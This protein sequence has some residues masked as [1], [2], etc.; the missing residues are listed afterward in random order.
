M[1]FYYLTRETISLNKLLLKRIVTLT[2]LFLILLI[3]DLSTEDSL[4]LN[5]PGEADVL[6]VL[7]DKGN[8]EEDLL[9][10]FEDFYTAQQESI[11]EEQAK[12]E[13]ELDRLE[14][15]RL[16]ALDDDNDDNEK[17]AET[18]AYTLED[19]DKDTDYANLFDPSID[20]TFIIDFTSLEWDGL[21]DDMEEYHEQYGTYK[22]NNYRQVDVTYYS[23]NEQIF[24]QDVGIRSK[25]NVYSRILPEDETGYHDIHYAL[26]FNETFDTFEGTEAHTNLK[27]R[28]VFDLEK[29]YFKWNKN[30]DQS[31]IS[32]IYSNHLFREAGVIAPNCNL[33]KFVIRIDGEV[34]QTSLYTV[35]ESLDEEFVRRYFQE[36]PTKEVGD[37][38]KVVYPGTLEALTSTDYYFIAQDNPSYPNANIITYGVR[39]W[40]LNE[41]PTYG[42]ETNDDVIN[43]DNLIDFT[44]DLNNFSGAHLKIY[45]EA[46]FDVDSFLRSL[47]C[48]VFLGNPDDYR[49]NVNNYYLYFDE[50]NYLTYIP[51]DYDW[52]MGQHWSEDN[53]SM[54][55]DIYNWTQ[56]TNRNTPLVDEILAIEEY[57][58]I[59]ENYLEQ[60]INDSTFS[61]QSFAT[62][63]NQ[64]EDIYGDEFNMSNDKSFYITSKIEHVLEDIE[65]YRNERN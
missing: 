35:M 46:N 36:T 60:F 1:L 29:L 28:E 41:R 18:L 62:L 4:L 65:Y 51:F 16:D 50:T 26:K 22:S 40:E 48:S 49:S 61:T 34:I 44:Q 32:E 11:L 47:A 23:D 38:Y 25:G 33:T 6:Q 10:S 3:L 59:Y 54:A 20:H 8:Q 27:T 31:Q 17:D 53:Y 56:L 24:I 42:K 39:N 45:L 14:E 9:D 12:L 55:F 7:V 58:I 13:S 15:E 43:Y 64:Y 19:R 21:I 2:G 57:R 63:Y 52:S 37:L 30:N 5:L